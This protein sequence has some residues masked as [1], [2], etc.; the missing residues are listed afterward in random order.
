V[1]FIVVVLCPISYSTRFLLGL[2]FL[3]SSSFPPNLSKFTLVFDFVLVDS[4]PF[5]F[6]HYSFIDKIV[7]RHFFIYNFF[8]IKAIHP[9]GEY[10]V[11][12]F[13]LTRDGATKTN[14]QQVVDLGL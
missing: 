5:E 6:V 4:N 14:L 12:C 1:V 7:E 10:S 13:L 2:Y 11:C 3:D 8:I 9:C